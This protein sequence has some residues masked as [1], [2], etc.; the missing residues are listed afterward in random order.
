MNKMSIKKIFCL[1]VFLRA[2]VEIFPM[3]DQKIITP[4]EWQY[5]A[6]N[7]LSL[8]HG[9]IFLSSSPLTVY[10]F[11]TML[12]D[13]D[14]E[15]LSEPGKRLYDELRDFLEGVSFLSLGSDA[16]L[17][18]VNPILSP[19]LYYRTDNSID[20]IYNNNKRAPLLSVPLSLSFSPYLTAEIELNVGQPPDAVLLEDNYGNFFFH[21]SFDFNIPRR[22]YLCLA[23]PLFKASGVQFKIGIG[24]DFIGRTHTGSIILSE[25]MQGV[26]YASLLLFSPAI[27]YSATILQLYVNK[28]FYFHNVEVRLFKKVSLSLTEGLLVNAPM[29]LRYFNP[30]MIYHSF[31][32]YTEYGD[33][34]GANSALDSG[35]SRTASFFGAKIEWQPFTNIRFYGLC[36][37]NEVQTAQERADEPESLRPDSLA[38]QAG[39]EW[40]VPLASSF[41]SFG[42][43]GV[44][45]FPYVYVSNN[46]DW[47]FYK[48]VSGQTSSL[49]Y[50]TGT[51][52][53]PDSAAA[54]AWAGFHAEKWS[55]SFSFLYLI[56]G[57]RSGT[58]V[59]DTD[60]YHPTRTGIFEETRLISPTGVRSHSWRMNFSGTWKPYQWLS[61]SL[62]P[63]YTIV[64]N[65]NNIEGGIRHGFEI[66]FRTQISPELF[67]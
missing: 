15:K 24:E 22:A 66:A 62:D 65:F 46:K 23:L 20:W 19:E 64:K 9:S 2:A 61:F 29:E 49:R 52:F 33:Y 34:N 57:E 3:P 30:V 36:A 44:Y 43:E 56:Q 31:S 27:E 8:E 12:A 11:K 53:G 32:A 58:G 13:I 1:C 35:D 54:S 50:W 6:L 26:T 25:N 63:G 59:F 60:T 17:V 42:L 5:E 39:S 48:P 67:R 55:L 37:F 38:F 28:Y 51:P 16:L 45:T 41:W 7:V 4:G 40:I 10:Q 18:D 21:K 47:S 14:R